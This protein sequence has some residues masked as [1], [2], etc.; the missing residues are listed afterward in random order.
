MK[1]NNNYFKFRWGFLTPRKADC[2]QRLK[3]LACSKTCNAVLC[4]QPSGFITE[5]LYP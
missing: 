4:E 5:N 2:E 3:G 1:K